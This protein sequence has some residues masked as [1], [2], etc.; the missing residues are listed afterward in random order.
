MSEISFLEENSLVL[1]YSLALVFFLLI[2]LVAYLFFQ[3]RRFKKGEVSGVYGQILKALEGNTQ[4]V[5]QQLVQIIDSVN[6]RLKG[7]QELIDKRLVE[8][9]G[10]IERTQN[11]VA[12]RLV[13]VHESL[14]RLDESQK[15][16]LD[17]GKDISSLQDIL[18][19]PKLRGGFGEFLLGDLLSQ[20]LPPKNYKIQYT[21]STGEQVDAVIKLGKGLVPIDSKFPID[22][23]KRY[24]N[25]SG[26]EKKAA[27]RAFVADIRRLI[28]DIAEKYIRPEEGTFDFALMYIPAENIYYE[29]IIRDEDFGGDKNIQNYALKRQVIPVSPNS[30]YAYLAAI[31]LG[32]KGMQIEENAR[33]ILGH[34]NRLNVDF[35][36]FR[37]DYEVLGTHLTNARNKYDDAHRKLSRFEDKLT[38]TESIG[39]VKVAGE[40]EEE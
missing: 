11:S 8:S 30:F 22:N 38:T 33:E 26:E 10:A 3:M 25:A 20:I 19:S 24:I 31:V 16:I 2:V 27:K 28:D 23:F 32:L 12:K 39:D 35:T 17:V 36:K 4:A 15:R 34:I 40:I 18:K 5:N 37:N 9:T 1:I 6:N 13:T 7:F 14:A 21:F 29:T